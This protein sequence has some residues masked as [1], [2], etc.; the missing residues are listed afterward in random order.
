MTH[1]G[2][3]LTSIAA[4]TREHGE[5]QLPD[6]AA[7]VPAADPPLLAGAE[8]AERLEVSVRT[9]RRDV[10]R[11]RELGYP[12]EAQR[13]VAG[14]YQLAAG[15]RCRRWCSTTRRRSRSRS[16]CRPPRGRGGRD[17]GGVGARAG[18]GGAGDAAAAA[19]PGGGAA[20]R[21]GPGASRTAGRP[22]TRRAH[23]VAQACRDAERLQFAYTA[24]D[25]SHRPAVEPHRLVLLGR[26]W[27][28]VAYDLHRQDWRSF[29]LDRL[30]APRRTGARFRP[31]ELPADDAAAFV[32]AGIRKLPISYEVEVLVDA[33]ADGVRAR[34]GR[35][36]SV[37]EA[38]DGAAA[39]DERGHAGLA[40]V[41]GGGGGRRV[42]GR[43]L[44]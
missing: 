20:D 25:G 12:V 39:A 43:G 6:A 26:R 5:H 34:V 31:R 21:D 41:R 2:Q 3:I 10:D 44:R 27:Y 32:R 18:Q 7:A 42:H 35:W 28:L 37:E 19:A 22:S 36:A 8:L 16:A 29:R 14:G 17:R 9:L 13:G 1:C 24:A 11:L 40:G 38:G 23:H 15:R 4:E 30:D 33:P